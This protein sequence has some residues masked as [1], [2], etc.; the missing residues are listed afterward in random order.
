MGAGFRWLLSSS[1]I[2]NVGDGI[3]LAAGPLLVASQTHDPFL[4]ALATL[5]QRLPWLLFGLHAGVMA[6]W[7]DRRVIV[8]GVDLVRALVLVTLTLTI[9]TSVVNVGVV[10][11]VLFVLGTAE[12]YA[13]T[14][15]STLLPMVVDKTDL[16]I[17][18]ARLMFGNITINRLAG[19][20]IGALLFAVGMAWPF[21]TQAVCVAFGAVLI[22]RISVEQPSRPAERPA[23][24]SEIAAGVRWVWHHSAVRTL[25]LTVVAF[26]ITFGAA[27]S[28]LVLYSIERLGLGNIGFG[29]LTAFGAAGGVLGTVIYGWLERNIGMANIMR[30]GLIIETLTHLS[31]AI[32]TKPAV[33]F[34]VFFVFGL[35]EASWGTTATTIRQRAVP[36]EFQGRVGSV[37]MVGVFG[38]LV[39]GAAIGGVIASVWGV[40][41]PLWFGFFGSVLILAAIWRQLDYI[42][43]A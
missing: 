21:A 43:H 39:V 37:Y 35:H 16:G 30:V 25:T 2:S 28:I 36:M 20:P 32:T 10:I 17:A 22:S 1:W 13:D 12:T 15:T 3:A 31:L 40:T 27:W 14:T 23:I 7:F 26:N 5:V 19:P 4:V 6:D 29:L 24:R 11:A 41:G 38:S 34:G 18:N 33:A 42:A 8:V 9:V